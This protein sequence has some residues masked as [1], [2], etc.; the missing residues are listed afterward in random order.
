MALL[1]RFR[2][3][4]PTP[5]TGR[6]LFGGGAPSLCPGL[7]SRMGHPADGGAEL[8]RLRYA[9]WAARRA[10]LSAHS[11]GAWAPER[12]RLTRW[13]EDALVA[14]RRWQDTHHPG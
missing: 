9:V 4:G 8:E 2:R 13:L 14:L 10:L 11:R 3:F 12:R 6:R 1:G 7:S 5:H